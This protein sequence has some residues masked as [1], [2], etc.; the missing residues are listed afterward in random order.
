MAN[1]VFTVETFVLQDEEGNPGKEVR[2]TPLPIKP[3][4]AFMAE[5]KKLGEAEDDEEGTE[6]L[7]NCAVI[8]LKARN[9]GL[10]D[11]ELENSLDLPTVIKIVEVAGGVNLDP[12]QPV[13]AT[14]K[15]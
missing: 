9:K 2:V 6:I 14:A 15:E 4:R 7:Y 13:P 11:E 3:L 5:F 1:Q 8:A 12:N 10:E